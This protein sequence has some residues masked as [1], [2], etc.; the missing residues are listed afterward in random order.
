MDLKILVN[1]L[2]L[3]WDDKEIEDILVKLD[4]DSNFI[5]R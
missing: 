4:V 2:Q 1:E 3:P 5:D